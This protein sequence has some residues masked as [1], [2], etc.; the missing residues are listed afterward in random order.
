MTD[1][2]WGFPP[3]PPAEPPAPKPVVFTNAYWAA[4]ADLKDVLDCIVPSEDHRNELLASLDAAVI[5]VAVQN[6]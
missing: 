3:R 5:D 4:R 2:R 6:R 1:R